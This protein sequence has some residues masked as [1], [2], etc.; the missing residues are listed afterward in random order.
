M[1]GYFNKKDYSI[2][3]RIK[4]VGFDPYFIITHMASFNNMIQLTNMVTGIPFGNRCVTLSDSSNII[5]LETLLSLTNEYN[6]QEEDYKKLTFP[7]T[8]KYEACHYTMVYSSDNYIM[9]LNKSTYIRFSDAV[10]INDDRNISESEFNQL[11][12]STSISEW[13]VVE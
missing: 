7:V 3:D 13:E 12:A 11:I 2:G 4:I 9:L 8:L 10:H 1:K 5:K 6:I